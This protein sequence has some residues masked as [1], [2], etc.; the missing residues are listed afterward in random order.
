VEEVLVEVDLYTEDLLKPLELEVL[1]QVLE[2]LEILII[3]YQLVVVL[4][5]NKQQ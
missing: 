4:V 1:I 3:F 2:V 5:F